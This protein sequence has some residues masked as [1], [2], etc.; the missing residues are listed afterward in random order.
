MSSSQVNKVQKYTIKGEI[1]LE[2]DPQKWTS[3]DEGENKES[4][5]LLDHE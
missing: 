1:A 4:S 3:A 5:F 2:I